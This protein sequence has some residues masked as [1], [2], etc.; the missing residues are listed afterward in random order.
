MFA[1][2]VQDALVCFHLT[3]PGRPVL[4]ITALHSADML[5]ATDSSAVAC[6]GGHVALVQTVKARGKHT[7]SSIQRLRKYMIVTFRLR[8]L[9]PGIH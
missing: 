3:A 4:Q 6:H 5:A 8:P 9:Y 7:F 2:L 1:S